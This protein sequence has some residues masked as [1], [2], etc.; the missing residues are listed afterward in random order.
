MRNYLLLLPVVGLLS[1]C[2]TP[3][4]NLPAAPEP[5]TWPATQAPAYVNKVWW[6]Q[7]RDDTLL[8]LLATADQDSHDIR[9]ATARLKE[10]RAAI[11]PSGHCCSPTLLPPV[12]FSAVMWA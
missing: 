8:N 7:G 10:A 9:I 6:T 5:V 11:P 2:S 1:A 12:W 4:A 3:T